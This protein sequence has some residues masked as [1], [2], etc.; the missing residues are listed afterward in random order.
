VE[1]IVDLRE[2]FYAHRG[3]VF[4]FGFRSF[5]RVFL[6]RVVLYGELPSPDELRI[7]MHLGDD[8]FIGAL[9]AAS[10][11]QGSGR[12]RMAA[13]FIYVWSLRDFIV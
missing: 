12:A 8:L 13:S 7:Y 11:S 4:A 3:M 5:V 1:E 9:R 6:Q 2:S 10:R